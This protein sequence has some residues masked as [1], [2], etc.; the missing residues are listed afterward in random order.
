MK[1]LKWNLYLVLLIT[2]FP[3]DDDGVPE[4]KRKSKQSLEKTELLRRKTEKS[5]ENPEKT[6]ILFKKW[7]L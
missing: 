6:E 7:K 3:R 4:K 2:S 5:E 1:T